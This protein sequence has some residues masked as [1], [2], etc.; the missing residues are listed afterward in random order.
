LTPK[1]CFDNIK[2][3]PTLLQRR[4][5]LGAPHAWAHPSADK[6]KKLLD[7]QVVQ[8]AIVTRLEFPTPIDGKPRTLQEWF[9]Q[10]FQVVTA[11][12]ANNLPGGKEK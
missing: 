1:Y 10:R 12:N 7:Q 8:A 3:M 4:E 2:V 6:V 9:D 5:C 11:T